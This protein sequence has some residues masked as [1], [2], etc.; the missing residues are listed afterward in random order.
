MEG[1][2]F[3][4][5]TGSLRAVI[6]YPGAASFG[7]AIL[8]GLEFGSAAPRENYAIALQ[9]GN[10]VLI[11]ALDSSASSSP[12]PAVTRRPDGIAWSGDGTVAVLYSRAGNWLQVISGLPGNPSAGTYLDVASLGGSL[13]AVAVDGTGKQIAVA[14]S[15]P[16]G[17]LYTLTASQAFAPI[18]ALANPVSLAFSNDGTQL[19]SIDAAGMQLAVVHLPG[20]DSQ[21]IALTGMAQPFAVRQAAD[22]SVYIAGRSDQV[23]RAYNLSSQQVVHELPLSFAPTGIEQF[24]ANS[25]LL[26][27]RAQANDPL[28][29]VTN[30][31]QPAAYFIPAIPQ[32][33]GRGRT[34]HRDAPVQS[35]PEGHG[36]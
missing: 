27:P 14:A 18:L 33:I 36:R 25:F 9:N 8:S 19:F 3:D 28:W 10:C 24:G 7:P 29:L 17:G 26:A 23:L 30:N 22:G 31:S 6:G 5:P 20:L 35:T 1:F 21:M 2:T 12:I 15:G 11:T 34:T 16:G 13:T 32:V 4:A